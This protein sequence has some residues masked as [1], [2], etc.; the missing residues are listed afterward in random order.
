[1]SCSHTNVILFRHANT[2]ILKIVYT[3]NSEI[4]QGQYFDPGLSCLT[5]SMLCSDLFVFPIVIL[6]PL[7]SSSVSLLSIFEYLKFDIR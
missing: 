2:F 7:I 1:M 3:L 6:N 4:E 5:K